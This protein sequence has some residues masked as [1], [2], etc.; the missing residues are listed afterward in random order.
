MAIL[1]IAFAAAAVLAIAPHLGGQVVDR[2]RP[3]VETALAFCRAEPQTCLKMAQAA[4]DQRTPQAAPQPGIRVAEPAE[5]SAPHQ[6]A[7]SA[8][9]VPMPPERPFGLRPALR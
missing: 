1:R 4:L 2:S 9:A 3:A 5:A 7:L 6:I 8:G